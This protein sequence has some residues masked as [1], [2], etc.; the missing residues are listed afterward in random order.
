MWKCPKCKEECEDNFDSCWS[1]GTGRDGA[2]PVEPFSEP[3]SIASEASSLSSSA[4]RPTKG[5]RRSVMSRYTDAYIIARTITAIGATVKFV[6]LALG[7]CI[8]VVG[9]VA[10]SQSAQ[11]A[12]GGVILA[13]IVAIPIYVLGILAQG[14]ILKATLDNAVN[15]SPLLS[16]DEMRQIMSLD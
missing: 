13:V 12:V 14:Q 2:P 3:G 8:A 16:K 15:S 10:S 7:G 9:L 4:A 11:F 5:G 1:C 6:G